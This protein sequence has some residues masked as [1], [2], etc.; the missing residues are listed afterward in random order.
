MTLGKPSRRHGATAPG[1]PHRED[2]AMRLISARTPA[3]AVS[4]SLGGSFPA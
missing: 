1:R 4:R 2:G 3:N